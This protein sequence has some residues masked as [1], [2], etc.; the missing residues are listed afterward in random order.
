MTQLR[1]V[2]IKPSKYALD[3]SVERF[4]KG[5][6]PNATLY[7]IASLTPAHIG[8]V[9][10]T[11]HLVDEYVWQDL[12]YLRW[13]H[14]E[15]GVITLLALVGVQSHQ[16]Q[17]ALDLAAYED[18]LSRFPSC[19]FANLAKARID[20]LKQKTALAPSGAANKAAGF[21]GNWDVT[22]FC[23]SQGKAL[24][25]TRLL[26]AVVA[27]GLLRAEDQST[28][29]PDWVTIE[30][31]IGKDGKTK[32]NARGFTGNP[33]YTAAENKPGTPY[34]YT[35]DAQFDGSSGTGKRN[36][37]RPCKLTFVKRQ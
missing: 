16:F 33:K 17:R 18:H 20:G 26:T 10:I 15:P 3:G 36:E 34:G 22:I 29:R 32:L 12:D 25:Y 27:N 24:G 4:K 13:L 21:D 23:E 14:N 5:F 8:D 7:H 30:G 9:P 37:L 6:L 2:L 1:V 11:V 35:V 31:E 19:S 28:G